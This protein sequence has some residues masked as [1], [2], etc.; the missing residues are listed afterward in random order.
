M[1]YTIYNNGLHEIYTELY[2]YFLKY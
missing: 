2:S 1:Q